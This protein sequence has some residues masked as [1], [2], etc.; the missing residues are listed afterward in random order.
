MEKSDHSE[1]IKDSAQANIINKVKNQL[2]TFLPKSVSDFVNPRLESIVRDALQKN[3]TFPAQS[4]ATLAQPVYKAAESLYE[5]ELK[6][7][8]FEKVDKSLYYLTHDKHQELFNSLLNSI[9]LDEAITKGD[10]NSDKVL[11]NENVAMM[12]TKTLLL[13]QTKGRRPKRGEPKK[14]FVEHTE[15][16]TMDAKENRM[17]DDVVNYAY[18]PQ[19]DAVL[20]ANNTP[21]NNWFTQ[22]PRPPTPD[23][24][25][26]KGKSIEDGPEQTWFNDLVSAKKDP[27]T[28]EKLMAT[29]IDFSKFAMNHLKLDKITK[30][31]LVGPVYKLLKET[32]KSSIELEYNMEECYKDLSDQLDWTNPEGDRCPYDLST[33]LPLKG[34]PSHLTI[35]AKHFFNNDLEYLKSTIL[36][37]KYTTSITKTMQQVNVAVDKLHGYGYLKEIVDMLLL[38]VQHKLFHLD[39]DAII[40]LAILLRMFTRS[41]VIKKRVEDVQL[42]VESYQKKL[43]NTKPQRDF[44]TIFAKE[45]YTPSFDPQGVVCEDLSNQ[46]RLMRADELY[47]FSDGTLKYLAFGRHL[48]E[49]HRLEM[50][51]Q[52]ARDAITIHPMMVSTRKAGDSDEREEFLDSKK[53]KEIESWIE[54]SRIVDSLDGSDEIEYFDTFPTLEELEY[55]EWLL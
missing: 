19:D 14:R 20:K 9:M 38:V 10:V 53:K 49:I 55:H 52:D 12:K 48:E 35:A 47:K 5:R 1:A 37:R 51:S 22:P 28:F 33:P 46:K 15:E 29:P 2:P 40:D 16:V 30:A 7:I 43:N 8:L 4:S 24:E 11:R 26:N 32:C 39:G 42:G 36:E 27:L 50:A 18:Q 44:P 17:N 34:H 45:P 21:N 3:Q 23:P 54:D 25:W 31:Y 6:N 41:L 13:D